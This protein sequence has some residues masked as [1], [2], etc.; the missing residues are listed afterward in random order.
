MTAAMPPVLLVLRDDPWS[1]SA[2]QALEDLG[3]EFQIT[4]V[5]R[6]DYSS[7]NEVP[8]LLTDTG[9]YVGLETIEQVAKEEYSAAV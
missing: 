1:E 2:I 8:K 7:P 9:M 4:E 6:H 3:V 5:S